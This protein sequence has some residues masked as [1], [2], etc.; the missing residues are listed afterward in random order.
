VAVAAACGGAA[1]EAG[2]KPGANADASAAPPEASPSADA[3]QVNLPPLA[4]PPD[5]APPDCNRTSYPGF[6]AYLENFELRRTSATPTTRIGAIYTAADL[7]PLEDA[8]RWLRDVAG[9]EQDPEVRG[10]AVASLLNHGERIVPQH[11]PL[12][13]GKP[14][15][16]WPAPADL[17]TARQKA[18]G[19]G[20]DAGWAALH[21]SVF[22]DA[23][24]LPL[25]TALTNDRNVFARFSSAMGFLGVNHVEAAG[26]VFDALAR[27]PRGPGNHFYIERSLLVLRALG[28]KGALAD[29]VAFLAEIEGSTAADDFG[30]KEKVLTLMRI[31]AG[32][33]SR[34]DAASWRAWLESTGQPSIGTRR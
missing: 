27:L 26:A 16:L 6:D 4:A 31:V 10:A 29:L 17:P 8:V 5:A 11:L 21:L 1:E 18:T 12:G 33:E 28:D 24:D 13:V 22:G 32:G 25:F 9:C 15:E 20:A 34:P 23:S 19:S 2:P 30:H 3:A 7:M 14:N